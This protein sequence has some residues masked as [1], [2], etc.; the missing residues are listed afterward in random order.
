LGSVAEGSITASLNAALAAATLSASAV[1]AIR[2]S[3]ALSLGA[4]T[5]VAEGAAPVPTVPF[6]L[7]GARLATGRL[8]PH[9]KARVHHRS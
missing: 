8:A 5:L 9:R 6:A 4:A 1:V 3:L 2:A 7:P